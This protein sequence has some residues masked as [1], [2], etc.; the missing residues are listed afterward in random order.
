M[1]VRNMSAR[2]LVLDKDASAA[3]EIRSYL[4]GENHQVD[5]LDPDSLEA[6]VDASH[7]YDAVLFAEDSCPLSV[8]ELRRILDLDHKST[9][10]VLLGSDPEVDRVVDIMLEGAHAYLTKPVSG[11]RLQG[12]LERGLENKCTLQD[13]MQL[14]AQVQES[15]R[16]LQEH[17]RTLLR[18][19]RHLER[20]TRQLRFLHELSL[21]INGSLDRHQVVKQVF[22]KLQDE[23]QVKWCRAHLV[24]QGNGE[25]AWEYSVGVPDPTHNKTSFSLGAGGK[26]MGT[27]E[28]A[29]PAQII[30]A[31][32]QLF[33]TIA[34]Q[35]ALALQNASHH[36]EV[37][38]LADSDALTRLK[39][40]RS[41]ERQLQRE[42]EIHRRYRDDLSLIFW[43]LDHFK[44]INDLHGHQTGDE[45]LRQVGYIM[46]EAFRNCDYVA[47]WGGD[48]FAAILPRTTKEQA[49]HS[50]ERLRRRLQQKQL[51]AGQ[52]LKVSASFGIADTTSIRS[53]GQEELIAMADQA[54]Y[55]AKKAGRNRIELYQG[56]E[57]DS[58]QSLQMEKTICSDMAV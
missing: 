26:S 10:L 50:A 32:R 52:D 12:V 31:D 47:R 1:K 17:K 15:N 20:R 46:Q 41:F 27:M 49:L 29:L 56:Y 2:V 44:E 57:R 25:P 51:N 55:Q 42:F 5:T 21:A 39:N 14:A 34:L 9:F 13:I 36:A 53:G 33:D 37:K 8:A 23:L 4:A 38:R 45:V 54:L 3:E 16:Q 48:E 6:E 28:V 58:C 18:E 19:K 22:V 24:S 43:D 11:R 40:R 7:S 35:V 30:E